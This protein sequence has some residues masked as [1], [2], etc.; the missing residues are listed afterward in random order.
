MD[1]WGGGN[2]RGIIL[3]KELKVGGQEEEQGR[4]VDRGLLSVWEAGNE[5]DGQTN[6]SLCVF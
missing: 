3:G 1:G 5:R 4:L 6:T 2:P